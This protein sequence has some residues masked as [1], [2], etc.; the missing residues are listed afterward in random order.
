MKLTK[1]NLISLIEEILEE[2]CQKGYTRL[3]R[4]EKTKEMF[5]RTYRNCV[6]AEEGKDPDK[7]Y[8]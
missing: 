7:R 5:G 4:L 1:E 6:K 3:T 8:G 2:R